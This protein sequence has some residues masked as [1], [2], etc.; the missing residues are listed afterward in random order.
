MALSHHLGERVGAPREFGMAGANNF[1]IA[2]LQGDPG[3]A[4]E[5]LHQILLRFASGYRWRNK[6][7]AKLP[8]AT[9]PYP[10]WEAGLC[11]I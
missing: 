7:V 1:A 5:A 6:I 3:V 10:H 4:G 9:S 2:H 8:S 11:A